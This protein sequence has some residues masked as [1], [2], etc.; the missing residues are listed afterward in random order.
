MDDNNDELMVN[1]KKNVNTIESLELQRDTMILIMSSR[2]SGKSMLMA[3]LIYYYLTNKKNKCDLL[4]LFSNTAHLKTNTN[5]Q[6]DFID[7]H[8]KI[9]AEYINV[10][11]EGLL[12][13]QVQSKFK[14]KLL[15]CFDDISLSMYDYPILSKLAYQG[16]HFH[17]TTILSSQ[18]TNNIICPG[19]RSNFSYLF[20]RRLSDKAIENNIYPS[21]HGF[22]NVKELKKFTHDNINNY[23]FLFYNNNQDFN[24]DSIKIVKAS[25]VPSNFKY[26]VKYPDKKEK[27]EKIINEKLKYWGRS[28]YDK[29]SEPDYSKFI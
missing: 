24:Q 9:P 28:I 18:I 13:N 23:Q 14:Y 2:C 7:K 25:V 10:V 12:K 8:S 5:P 17:I 26:I 22:S 11:V 15:L 29:N 19:I 27:K 3:N 20:F 21:V 1:N 4:Y 6:Y 16:R